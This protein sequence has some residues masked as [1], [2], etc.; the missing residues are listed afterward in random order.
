MRRIPML[1]YIWTVA[2]ILCLTPASAASST[3]DT[4]W[5]IGVFDQSSEEFGPTFEIIPTRCPRA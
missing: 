2:L 3:E 5:Q 4:L 1:G